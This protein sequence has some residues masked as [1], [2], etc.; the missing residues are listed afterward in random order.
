MESNGGKSAGDKS[1]HIHI[2]FFF[3]HDVLNRNNIEL[4]HFPTEIMVADYF[5]K[6]L[7]GSLLR[8]MRDIIIG[9]TAFPG[10][11]R[12]GHS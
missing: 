4:L 1:R 2:K 10:E 7:Q 11:E 3:I 5:T 8:K 9:L 6:P 12:D